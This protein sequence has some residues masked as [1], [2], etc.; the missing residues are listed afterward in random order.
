MATARALIEQGRAVVILART[1]PVESIAADF[2]PVDLSNETAIHR[3]IELILR[4]GPIDGIVN[5]VGKTKSETI[6]QITWSGFSEQ[7]DITLRP[8]V[9]LMQA[10]VEHMRRQ[11]WGRIVNITSMLTLG[12][13]NRSS[14]AAVKSALNSFTRTWALELAPFDVTVNSVAPGPTATELFRV[15]NPLGSDNEKRYI[16]MMP[17]KRLASPEEIAAAVSFFC[18]D[19]ASIITGQTLF[20]DGGTTVGRSI[21]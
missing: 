21:G 15:N 7:A 19:A 16:Q 8:A 2:I 1:A 5:N 14:Y 11:R 12:A 17:M 3:A 20:A 13:H 10:A 6:E 9:L 4:D 18:S